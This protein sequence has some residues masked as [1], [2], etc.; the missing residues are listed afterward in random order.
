MA[1]NF[2]PTILLFH[3][4]KTGQVSW[5]QEG[6]LICLSTPAVG[7][8]ESGARP[9]LGSAWKVCEVLL[10]RRLGAANVYHLS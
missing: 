2:Q 6:W 7:D 9:Q 1:S 5:I 8:G 3:G 4:T 10:M